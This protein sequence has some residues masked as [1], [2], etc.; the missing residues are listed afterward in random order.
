MRFFWIL[1]LLVACGQINQPVDWT[2]HGL[3]LGFDV[4]SPEGVRFRQDPDAPL[5]TDE[6]EERV[7]S[8][9]RYVETCTGITVLGPLVIAL[10]ALPAPLEPYGGWTYFD[11]DVMIVIRSDQ[12]RPVAQNV[13]M[14]HEFVHY[15]LKRGG[16]SD[17]DNRNHNSPFFAACGS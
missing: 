15:V 14:R 6:I 12:L 10:P 3:G 2:D 1:P 7:F 11:G 16:L 17:E 8:Q 4:E 5:T 9:Y 13:V